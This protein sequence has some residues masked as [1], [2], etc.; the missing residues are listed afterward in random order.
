[1]V[2]AISRNGLA[3]KLPFDDENIIAPR[4]LEYQLSLFL[5]ARLYPEMD[6][7]R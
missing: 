5:L 3:G 6:I 4:H 2:F 1:M 7:R